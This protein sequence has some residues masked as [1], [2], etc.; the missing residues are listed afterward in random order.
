MKNV[1]KRLIPA[2]SAGILV[3]LALMVQVPHS[4]TAL[5]GS[6]AGRVV[7]PPAP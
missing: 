5:F 6:A 7:L 1:M 2:L 3:G 4:A